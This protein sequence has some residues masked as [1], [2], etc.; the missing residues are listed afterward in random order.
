MS[1]FVNDH[2]IQNPDGQLINWGPE[3]KFEEKKTK[4][5]FKKMLF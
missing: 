5:F 3:K 1:Q 4:I 2:E